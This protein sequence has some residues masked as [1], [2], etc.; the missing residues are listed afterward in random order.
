MFELGSLSTS[1]SHVLSCSSRLNFSRKVYVERVEFLSS[2]VKLNLCTVYFRLFSL[3]LLAMPFKEI[4]AKVCF[5]HLSR[6]AI[7]KNSLPLLYEYFSN[8]FRSI[9]IWSILR[10]Q[11]RTK[12]SVF[13][14]S[15]SKLSFDQ[16]DPDGKDISADYREITTPFALKV[17]SKMPPLIR[18]SCTQNS[19]LNRLMCARIDL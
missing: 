10:S 18:T 1:R 17:L 4:S 19:L 12:L 9:V 2:N 11:S 13:R 5:E 7:L 15:Q 8:I 14:A 16:T 3:N 6:D